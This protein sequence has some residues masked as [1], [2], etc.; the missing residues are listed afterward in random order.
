MLCAATRKQEPTCWPQPRKPIGS[1]PVAKPLFPSAVSEKGCPATHQD[2]HGPAGFRRCQPGRAKD[3]S[4]PIHRWDGREEGTSPVRDE[5]G[6]LR[7]VRCSAVPDGTCPATTWPPSVET[8]GYGLPPCR[9]NLVAAS[10]HCAHP[11]ARRTELFVG[12]HV[13]AFWDGFCRNKSER[14]RRPSRW[15]LRRAKGL[16]P[17]NRGTQPVAPK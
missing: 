1:L 3:N 11:A 12:E 7:R 4:P 13:S 6:D 5:R 9:A 2:L 15:E 16:R 14:T 17:A 8:P 10:P